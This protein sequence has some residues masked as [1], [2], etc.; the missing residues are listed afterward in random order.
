M[1][2]IVRFHELGGPEV[3]RIEDAPDA[4]PHTNEVRL[5]VEAIGLNRAEI[6]FRLGRYLEE[7][8]L[9]SRLGYE[10]SG[11]VD[12]VGE[13]DQ[14]RHG[15]TRPVMF[16]KMG[17]DPSVGGIGEAFAAASLVAVHQGFGRVERG[18]VRVKR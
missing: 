14:D 12:A 3:L 16:G 8:R 5:R 10:A 17:V 1:A 15:H 13:A 2:K 18:A 7:P 11:I 9:P 6:M 4:T